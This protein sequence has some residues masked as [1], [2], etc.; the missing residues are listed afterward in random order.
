MPPQRWALI[1][2]VGAGSMGEGHLNAFLRRG[3]SVI[4]TSIDM[5]F[6]ES[7]EVGEGKNGA[8]VVKLVLDVTS[9]ESIADAVERTSKVTG[10]RLDWLMSKWF[11]LFT[12][13]ANIWAFGCCSLFSQ[14][15]RLV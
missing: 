15:F 12:F 1:T 7:L 4:A 13:R 9:P 6:M 8:Y 14:P 11:D 2:G 5:K 3:I 10:G